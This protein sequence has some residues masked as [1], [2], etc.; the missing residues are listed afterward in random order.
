MTSS[1]V[2]IWILS[3]SLMLWFISSKFQ[4][5]SG[6][7]VAIWCLWVLAVQVRH[8]HLSWSN[9]ASKMFILPGW[10]QPWACFGLSY[11]FSLCLDTRDGPWPNPT[12]AYFWPAVNKRLTRLR[13][14]Y[15]LTQPEEI[16]FD[17]KG[18]K[19]KK[20][21]FLRE[22]FQIQTHTINGWPDLTRATK[23]WPNPGQKFLTQTHH[24][25]GTQIDVVATFL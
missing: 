6:I 14:T 4:E 1:V 20:L 5:W 21:I 25:F 8:K 22:I 19:L 12:Q 15:F 24:Y 17:P 9:L 16:F 10:S 18:K 7:L 11:I 3:S 23:N 13:P 2:L